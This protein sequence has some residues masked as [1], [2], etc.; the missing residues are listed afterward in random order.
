MGFDGGDIRASR[1]GGGPLERGATLTPAALEPPRRCDACGAKL[2]VQVLPHGF[3]A[4]CTP[5][6]RRARYEAAGPR[7]SIA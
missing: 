4:K 2:T 5:C 1:P 6:E 7:A 3:E